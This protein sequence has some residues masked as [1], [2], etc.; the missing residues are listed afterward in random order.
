MNFTSGNLSR[1]PEVSAIRF[2][3]TCIKRIVLIPCVVF[4]FSDVTR[5]VTIRSTQGRSQVK[6]STNWNTTERHG[7]AT[8]VKVRSGFD[9]KRVEVNLAMSVQQCLAC[10][11]VVSKLSDKNRSCYS[12]RTFSSVNRF[13]IHMCST[14]LA[15]I[16]NLT[17]PWILP[18]RKHQTTHVILFWN[19]MVL[20]QN[21]GLNP[22]EST[23]NRAKLKFSLAVKILILPCQ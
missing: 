11:A 19:Q 1:L 20:Q 23:L 7:S 17:S 5:C 16:N 18:F 4:Q 12:F 8:I 6:T 10:N 13:W 3:F 14:C 9:C 22:S 2:P 21:D 15:K